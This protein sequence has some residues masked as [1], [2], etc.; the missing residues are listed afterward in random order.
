MAAQSDH[1][2]VLKLFL[3]HRP[4]LV[5]APNKQGFT[6]AHIAATKGSVAVLKELMKFNV[7]VVKSAR[8]KVSL[9]LPF[10]LSSFLNSG[11]Y[12]IRF[13]LMI[14]LF[15]TFFRLCKTF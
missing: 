4:E 6:C 11:F 12:F 13:V 10:H 15:F 9:S 2:E 5:S 14:I 8:I 1:P 3:Q 7:E